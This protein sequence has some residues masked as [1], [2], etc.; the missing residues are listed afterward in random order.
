MM[1]SKGPKISSFMTKESIG[2]SSITVGA[3]LL[4]NIEREDIE[5]KKGNE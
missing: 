4:K 2:A 1:G 5:N 3:I